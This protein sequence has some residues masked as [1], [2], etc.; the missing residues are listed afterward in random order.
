MVQLRDMML[1]PS[2]EMEMWFASIRMRMLH[3]AKMGYGD[4][5]CRMVSDVN[6]LSLKF[7]FPLYEV[8]Y[9]EKLEC[10]V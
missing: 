7:Q 1:L 4:Q 2:S 10:P 6:I 8:A 9:R 3:F 5:D